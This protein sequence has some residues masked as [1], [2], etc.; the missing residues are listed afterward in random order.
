MTQG[1]HFKLSRILVV[2][3]LVCIFVLALVFHA[4]LASSGTDVQAA[5]T[6]AG[7]EKG[8]CVV[9]GLPRSDEPASVTD[10]ARAGG[11]LVYFQSPNADEVALVR[12]AAESAGLL[13]ARIFVNR[14]DWTSVHLADN[15]AGAVVV[16]PSAQG[17]VSEEE[18]LRVL[19]PGGKAILG[20][21]EIVK[22]HPQGTDAWSHPYHGP[23]NNPQST[24]Q[25][26]RAPYLTQFLAEPKFSCMP[27]VTVAAR[28]RLFKAFGHL[29]HKANQIPVLNTVMCINAYNGTI[30]WKRK[31]KEDFMIH[32]NTMIATPETLYLADNE[33]CKLIDAVTGEVRDEITIPDGLADGPVWKWMAMEDGVLYALVGGQEVH[34]D[35]RR[36][37]SR[38]LGH[39]GWGM[40]KGHAYDDPKTN[41]GFGR[42]F[43]AIDPR[44]KTILWHHGEEE[45]LD[46]RGVCMKNGRIYFYSPGKLL[47]CLD[48]RSSQVLWKTSDADLLEAI[49]P[50]GPAQHWNTGF[51][52]STYV[53]CNDRLLF[54]AG[55]QRSLLVA[56]S[57]EDGRLVWQMDHGNF[58]LV[59]R[60]DALYAAGRQ[61]MSFK[62]DYETGKELDRFVPRSTCTRATGSVDSVFYRGG[63][64]WR[65]DVAA[66]RALPI[67]PMRPPCQD[68]VLISDGLLYWGP[69]MCGCNLSLYGHVCLAPAEQPAVETGS[70]D[71]RLER[72][73]GDPTTIEDFE[74]H[75]GDWPSYRADNAR[76]SRTGVP[77][78]AGVVREWTFTPPSAAFPSAPIAVGETVFVADRRG[79]V[80][81][82]SGA[83][84]ELRWKAYTGGAVYFAPAFWNGRVYVGSADGWVYAYEAATGR[85][86]WRFRAAPRPRL[87]PVFGKLT[88]TW[89]VAGGVV[90]Q[91]GVVYAA[92]GIANYDGTHVYALDAVTGQVRWHNATSGDV[93]SEAKT[94]ASLQGNLYLQDGEL[95]FAGGNVCEVA[96][97]DIE[98]GR[99][100]NPPPERVKA[101]CRTAFYA[102]YPE[103]GRYQ[104]L[105]HTVPGGNTLSYDVSFDRGL[106]S[107]L[108]LLTP[109]PPGTPETALQ[110]RRTAAKPEDP[111]RRALWEVKG[112]QFQS[113]VVAP[114]V[115]LAAGQTGFTGEGRFFL[116]AINV[117][118]GSDIWRVKLPAASVKG[119]IAVDHEGRVLVSLAD[120]QV[121]CFA[122]AQG[123]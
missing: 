118:D 116:A 109:F 14:G 65:V 58:Q 47:G 5:V 1:R 105:D 54:F 91:D 39:W 104:W 76:T 29:A 94:G 7:I 84:G 88:S 22:P 56:V 62:L 4:E 18:L 66:S 98:T 75:P 97:Y 121:L 20:R 123:G 73:E 77:L 52:T 41:F 112:C 78:P 25:I 28:G 27:Q 115:V 31:L 67:T 106:H 63:G 96:R 40:W 59:L 61:R 24:D 86:L 82:L 30:L 99:C 35:I 110:R 16:A 113:F 43:V 92:A 38:G 11:L 64:T 19:H 60:D 93:S 69:W 26:A 49:G 119:G 53:K 48:A 103:Y 55:P 79:V 117:K 51:A 120:G 9:L 6:E 46:S 33:S 12:E 71:F 10:L 80:R 15:L 23:D 87:I 89:P 37:R 101:T 83:N 107:S 44:T 114:D 100:L 2:L 70:G 102:Y 3:I 95:R 108:A 13:G 68:G 111:K 36:G 81:A 85:R 74:A 21:K 50:E 122:P 57:T 34:V 17:G 42:T 45:F 8:I 90:V 32:R 72:G